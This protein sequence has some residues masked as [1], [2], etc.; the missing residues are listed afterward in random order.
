MFLSSSNLI[1]I[2]AFSDSEGMRFRGHSFSGEITA[3]STESID[4]KIV[5]ERF[6]NG[7]KLM[8][9]SVGIEDQIS[10]Q[11]VDKDNVLGLGANILLDEF[12]KDFYL[13][14]NESLEVQLDYPARII[15]GLY[16]RL[17]Y[18]NTNDQNIKV[19]CNLYLHWKAE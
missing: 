1:R 13:P 8:V 7:G 5:E 11:V 18:K 6:I 4:Y 14:Q 16:L 15:A 3:N 17:I 19:R 9:S 12:I 10:F 2:K